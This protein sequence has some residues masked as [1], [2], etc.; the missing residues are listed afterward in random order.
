MCKTE[1]FVI[2][3]CFLPFQPLTTQKIKILKLEKI[4]ED[5][6]NLHICNINDNNMMYGSWDKKHKEQNFCHF[7]PFFCPFTPHNPKNQNFEKPKKTPWDIII[8]HKCI[9]NYDHMLYCSW[10]VTD[11]IVIFHFGLFF[12]LYP[13]NSPKKQNLKKMK[14]NIWK[15]HHFT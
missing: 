1:I 14:K 2:L 5:I 10:D 15:Y 4:P 7:G 12:S 11:V 13:P 9:K 6:I 8:L 3:D